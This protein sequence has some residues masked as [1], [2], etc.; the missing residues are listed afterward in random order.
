M[1]NPEQQQQQFTDL[2]RQS[3]DALVTAVQ[4][5]ADSV[6][7]LSGA[8]PQV[9]EQ[10]P[11]VSQLV[12]NSFA[13]ARQLLDAQQ[14]VTRTLLQTI[15]PSAAD[16]AGAAAESTARFAD[17][18]AAGTARMTEMAADNTRAAAGTASDVSDSAAQRTRTAAD[19]TAGAATSASRDVASAAETTRG[20]ATSG[21]ST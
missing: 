20:R 3:Q 6:K 18:V 13:F 14:E 4:A 7:R 1:S 21:S 9:A 10:V 16:V 2:A 17:N 12:D 8:A 19:A 11:D 5:W 15:T